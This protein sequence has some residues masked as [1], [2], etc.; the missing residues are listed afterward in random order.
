MQDKWTAI[1]HGR[2]SHINEDENWSVQDLTLEDFPEEGENDAPFKSPDV[3]GTNVEAGRLSFIEMIKVSKI[4]SKVLKTFFTLRNA[5][6]QDTA[7]LYYAALPILKELDDWYMNI[8]PR[9]SMQVMTPRQLCCNGSLHL[10]YHS[11]TMTIWRRVIRSTALEPLCSDVEVL[12]GARKAAAEA[13]TNAI[14]FKRREITGE[15]D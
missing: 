7:Q 3:P 13:A 11:V 1:V 9:L 2:P 8:S 10:C 5:K 12:N 14:T 6:S 15:V 4:L